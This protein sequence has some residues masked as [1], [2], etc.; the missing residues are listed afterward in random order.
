M[1]D[2]SFTP[3]FCPDEIACQLVQVRRSVAKGKKV[4]DL[5]L[6]L[7]SRLINRHGKE[8][9]AKHIKGAEEAYDLLNPP[10]EKAMKDTM[11]VIDDMGSVITKQINQI[12][13]HYK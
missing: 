10:S 8:L 1:S 5:A 2:R 13:G 12:M 4:P 6:Q 9:A 3:G 7:H 11:V